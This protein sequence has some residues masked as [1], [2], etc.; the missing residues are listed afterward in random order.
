M[1]K[2]QTHPS[3]QRVVASINAKACRTKVSKEKRTM[4]KLLYSP[5]DMN[6]AFKQSLHR[7]GWAESRVSYWVTRN[8]KLIRKT[9]TMTASEQ[10]QEILL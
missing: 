6:A 2:H 10:K 8:E 9:L 7:V 5:I 3:S 1:K 4:D